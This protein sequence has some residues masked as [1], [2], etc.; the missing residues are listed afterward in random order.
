MATIGNLVLFPNLTARKRSAARNKKRV[1]RITATGL[2]PA[3][4]T[5][6]ASNK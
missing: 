1:Q 3:K 4:A 5:A 2:G 6:G